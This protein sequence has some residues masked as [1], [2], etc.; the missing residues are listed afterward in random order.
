M[1]T[2]ILGDRVGGQGRLRLGC[3]AVVFDPSRERLLLT[4]R[5]DNGQW[6]LPGG[7]VN[8]GESVAEACIR[9]VWE[10]TGLRGRVVRLIGVYSDPNRLVIYP[11]GRKIQIVALNF[12]VEIT[13]GELGLS[14]ETTA[15]GYY[16]RAEASELELFSN[17]LERIQ[18]AFTNKP[19]AFIK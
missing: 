13:G 5:A 8:P 7:G 14:S 12:E 3:T 4:R 19:D 15:Y 1:T 11:D 18:D 17:H 2:T 16:T 9:E 10:E 6:C